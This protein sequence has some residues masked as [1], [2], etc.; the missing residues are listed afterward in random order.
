[1]NSAL[2]K[3]ATIFLLIVTAS[4]QQNTLNR[5]TQCGTPVNGITLCL[6]ESAEPDGLVFEIKNVGDADAVL[7]LGMMLANGARQYPTAIRLI[8]NT[9]GGPIPHEL[10]GPGVIAAR[11][12]PFIVP[13][14]SSAALMLSL[15][16]SQYGWRLKDFSRDLKQYGVQAEF[17]GKGVSRAQTNLDT[18][19]L[20][21]MPYWTGTVFS[22]T[23]H[24]ERK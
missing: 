8:F 11:V 14:P 15:H 22:N 5:S 7:N 13:L 4:P 20:S 1:M 16:P 18:P 2:L 10:E 3:A 12:D 19:G 23:V 17:I 21:L 24:V 6:S 9:G